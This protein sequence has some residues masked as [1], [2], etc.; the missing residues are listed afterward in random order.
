MKAGLSKV[1][2]E[3]W[4]GRALAADR[5]FRQGTAQ[6]RGVGRAQRVAEKR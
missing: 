6:G 5:E 1:G 3:V 2:K 4:A